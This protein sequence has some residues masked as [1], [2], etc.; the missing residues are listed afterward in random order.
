MS[1]LVVVLLLFWIGAW[2]QKKK[3]SDAVTQSY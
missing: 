1:V 2:N 3:V